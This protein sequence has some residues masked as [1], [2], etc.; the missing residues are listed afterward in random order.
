MRLVKSKSEHMPTRTQSSAN[1]PHCW[2]LTLGSM[3][4]IYSIRT[5]RL[6]TLV[7]SGMLSTGRQSRRDL[8]KESVDKLRRDDCKVTQEHGISM[9]LN[10]IATFLAMALSEVRPCIDQQRSEPAQHISLNEPT[11]EDAYERYPLPLLP[12]LFTRIR[13]YLALS[14]SGMGPVHQPLTPLLDMHNYTLSSYAAFRSLPYS[15]MAMT[16]DL[17]NHV[18]SCECPKSLHPELL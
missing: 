17:M 8:S 3:R 10:V 5:E 7:L 1:I 14:R 13:S 16:Q 4:I 6:S 18:N 15:A 2:A 12:F 11:F 9:N